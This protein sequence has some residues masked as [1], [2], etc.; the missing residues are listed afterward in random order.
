MAYIHCRTFATGAYILVFSLSNT[1]CVTAL[2]C[3]SWSRL[4]SCSFVSNSWPI[5]LVVIIVNFCRHSQKIVLI[6]LYVTNITYLWVMNR[7]SCGEKILLWHIWCSD[8]NIGFEQF[9]LLWTVMHYAAMNLLWLDDISVNKSINQ[10]CS[11][12]CAIFQF[13]KNE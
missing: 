13:S 11:W 4:Y 3:K 5:T 9:V 8:V 10:S 12:W 1:V 7:P 2:P 6:E